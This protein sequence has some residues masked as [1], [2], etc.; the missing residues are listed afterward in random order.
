MLG[1]SSLYE[2]PLKGREGK[3]KK[4]M[5][6]CLMNSSYPIPLIFQIEALHSGF[7]IPHAQLRS[8]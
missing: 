3:K 7:P 2:F 4:T 6:K 5:D 8:G 1:C